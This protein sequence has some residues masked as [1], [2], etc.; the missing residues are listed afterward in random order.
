LSDKLRDEIIAEINVAFE[1]ARRGKITLHETEIIDHCGSEKQRR[2]AQRLDTES[3]WQDVP[4]SV[5]ELHYSALSFLCPESFR[6]YLPAYMIW[7]LRY[8]KISHSASSDWTIYALAPNT[9]KPLDKRTLERFS[10]F[11]L[12]QKRAVQRFLQFMVDHGDGHADSWQ[13]ELALNAY[14]NEA[15][16]LAS[17][18]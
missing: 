10:L 3:R 7:S 1:N 17:N 16:G 18:Q 9:N 2:K 14:W 15:V 13:A 5:I 11:S 8:F 12:A 4:A 6:Y